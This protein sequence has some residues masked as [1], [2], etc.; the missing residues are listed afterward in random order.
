MRFWGWEFPPHRDCPPSSCCGPSWLDIPY[1][2]GGF[3]GWKR[4]VLCPCAP[5]EGIPG[6]H[7]KDLLL[8][9][10]PVLL[11]LFEDTFGCRAPKKNPLPWEK[12]NHFGS[13]WC[14]CPHNP[15][16]FGS[17]PPFL[18]PKLPEIPADST[19]NHNRPQTSPKPHVTGMFV[20]LENA[21][22]FGVFVISPA[23]Q[24][25]AGHGFEPPGNQ[26][27][28]FFPRNSRLEHEQSLAWSGSSS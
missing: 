2:W 6:S 3:Y 23:L 4:E 25:A 21:E 18:Q 19:G 8:W 15:W 5:S 13:P 22:I 28:P 7:P 20:R 10:F 1:F 16:K 27:I 11:C 9:E 24:R 17:S 14:V 12:K 26:K